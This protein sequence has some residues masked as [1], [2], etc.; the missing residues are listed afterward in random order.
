MFREPTTTFAA[1]ER[2]RSQLLAEAQ[3]GDWELRAHSWERTRLLLLLEPDVWYSV[4]LFFEPTDGRFLCWYVNFQD[5][6]RRSRIGFGTRDL[7]LDLVV[8][9]DR[10]WGWKDEDEFAEL[11]LR[12]MVT[13][14][15]EWLVRR[16]GED[17]LALVEAGRPPFDDTW[18]A[19]RP[20]PAWGLPEL[21]EGWERVG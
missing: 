21:P 6:F 1:R 3:R 18:T 20:D 7:V 4:N 13:P 17:V 2:A 11:V 12:R 15:E 9:P 8:G 16:A 19:W 10:K 14:E 5:P